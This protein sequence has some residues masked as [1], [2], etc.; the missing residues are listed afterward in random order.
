MPMLCLVEL[1]QLCTK[2]VELR[3]RD[4]KTTNTLS[5]HTEVRCAISTNL[6]DGRGGPCHH[7]IVQWFLGPVNSLAA[8]A[9]KP[10]KICPSTRE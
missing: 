4:T 1:T 6:H 9:K 3:K 7:F 5:P 10:R 8:G 2:V